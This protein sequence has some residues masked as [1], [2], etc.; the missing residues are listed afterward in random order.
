MTEP[1]SVLR[2]PSPTALLAHPLV[3]ATLEAVG[4]FVLVL[5]EHREVLAM[6]QEILEHLGVSSQEPLL[7]L[8]PGAILACLHEPES[9]T[10]CGT[11]ASCPYCGAFLTLAAVQA[12]RQPQEG[13]CRLL[14]RRQGRLQATEFRV[15]ALPVEVAGSRL[16][17]MVMQDISH[18]RRRV[19]LER[20]FLHDLGN[21]LHALTWVSQLLES[22]EEQ[23]SAAAHKV[24]ELVRLLDR[25]V[26]T[27][28]MLVR[29]EG[30]DLII[31]KTR[32]G[33]AAFFQELGMAFETHTLAQGRTLV[34][35]LDADLELTT[36]RTLLFRVLSNMV[37]NALEATTGEE[38]VTVDVVREAG[39]VTIR[40]ANP[41]V[42]AP[43]VAA[44]VFHRSFTT[45]GE[46]GRGLGTYSMKL[47]GE[48][49]LGGQVAFTSCHKN[50]TVFYI[51]LPCEGVDLS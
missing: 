50:G 42:M 1:P 37:V 51:S 11:S 16:I 19:A 28:Q 27:Q 44:Q 24:V 29:A 25:E 14:A 13:E 40:V 10:G 38:Q 3:N 9:G 4:G 48:Q 21:T 49:Y 35:P 5:N 15:K 2:G 46:P 8:R 23:P 32:F 43:P 30:G 7:G 20:T 45:R 6:N 36:D 22:R 33:L 18:M 41:G 26:T 34:L 47:L 17:L 31:R 39:R 12:T